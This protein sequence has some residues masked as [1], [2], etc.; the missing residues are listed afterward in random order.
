MI[1]TRML[2][3]VG[4]G[5]TLSLPSVCAIGAAADGADET[6]ATSVPPG[7][8]APRWNRKEEFLAL[9]PELSIDL[10]IYIDPHERSPQ[11]ELLHGWQ[12]VGEKSAPLSAESEEA[13]KSHLSDLLTTGPSH[14]SAVSYCAFS[15]RQA[16][17]LSNGVRQF[18]VLICFQCGE[19]E[20]YED[21]KLWFGGGFATY[22]FEQW[23]S[24]FAAAGL[25]EPT[26]KMRNH[27]E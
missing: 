25:A 11:G 14:G 10:L 6:S 5:C 9:V 19:Y 21:G 16:L 20:V 12:I 17:S 13:L 3:I 24:G 23:K 18:D 26:W 27:G 4:L 8:Q 1:R 22:P 15:P 7:D 2:L